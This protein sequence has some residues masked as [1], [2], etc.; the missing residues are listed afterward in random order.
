MKLKTATKV[1][2]GAAVLGALALVAAKYLGEEPVPEPKEDDDFLLACSFCVARVR[3]KKPSDSPPDWTEFYTD[4]DC[5]LCC[6]SPLCKV[7]FARYISNTL[8]ARSKA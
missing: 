8:T 7:K 6:G 1:G 2:I 5:V 3:V 4:K